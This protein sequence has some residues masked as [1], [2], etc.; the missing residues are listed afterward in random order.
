MAPEVIEGKPYGYSCD[1][2]SLGVILYVMLSGRYP[3]NGKNL[4][5]EIINNSHSFP[6]N[7]WGKFSPQCTYFIDRL[8][9]KDPSKRLTADE[10]FK[11]PWFDILTD[12]QL[13]IQTE[14]GPASDD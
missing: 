8:L 9:N 7:V 3:F 5:N 1:M 2:W 4:E 10:A 6:K 13:K 11:H 14:A 12:E